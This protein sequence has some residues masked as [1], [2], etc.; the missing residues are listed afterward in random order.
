MIFL[1]DCVFVFNSFCIKSRKFQNAKLLVFPFT[2][3]QCTEILRIFMIGKT[4]AALE[5]YEH[6]LVGFHQ[7]YQG[8]EEA[9]SE[10]KKSLDTSQKTIVRFPR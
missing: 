3:V 4:I 2:V 5:C 1:Y 6:S 7:P 9:R 10:W 8:F